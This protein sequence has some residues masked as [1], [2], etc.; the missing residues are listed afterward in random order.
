MKLRMKVSG[1]V[2]ALGV[3]SLLTDASSEMIV[4]ILP[5]FLVFVLHADYFLVGFIDGLAEMCANVARVLSGWYADRVSL[6]KPFLLFG[7]GIG[8]VLKPLMGSS[9]SWWHIA[10]LRSTERVGKGVRGPPR[11]AMVAEVT[12]KSIRGRAFIARPPGSRP[13]R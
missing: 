1:V 3:V 10:A 7:Y 2:V 12:D 6:R 5:L 4:P 8:A 11:D 9:T 13:A